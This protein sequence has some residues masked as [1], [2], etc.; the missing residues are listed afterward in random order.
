MGKPKED[1]VPKEV[2]AVA[3]K[4]KSITYSRNA[5]LALQASPL[6]KVRPTEMAMIPGV[7]MPSLR[8]KL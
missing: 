2:E 1:D 7:T 8:A 6:S 5:L 3:V 4:S